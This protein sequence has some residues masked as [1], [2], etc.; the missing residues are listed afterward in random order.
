MSPTR[1]ARR[2]AGRL[3]LLALLVAALLV[4]LVPATAAPPPWSNGQGV[5]AVDDHQPYGVGN[6]RKIK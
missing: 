1:S 4:V 6:G 5:G 3:A 2:L